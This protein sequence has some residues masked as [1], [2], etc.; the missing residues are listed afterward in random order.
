MYFEIHWMLCA[1]N[2]LF[3]GHLIYVDCGGCLKIE[4]VL[5]GCSREIDQNGSDLLRSARCGRFA[6]QTDYAEI[7]GHALQPVND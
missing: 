4:P 5:L 3:G 6:A 1:F 7:E 2:F